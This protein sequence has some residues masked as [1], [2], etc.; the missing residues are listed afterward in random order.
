MQSC[1]CSIRAFEASV[2]GL[3]GLRTRHPR[4]HI[5]FYQQRKFCTRP[6]FRQLESTTISI[7]GDDAFI[8]FEI[9]GSKA[10]I[11]IQQSKLA[12]SNLASKGV[13][14]EEL[15]EDWH[16]EIEIASPWPLGTN[17]VSHIN[18]AASQDVHEHPVEARAEIPDYE[19][20]EVTK[21]TVDN[22]SLHGLHSLDGR[23]TG[24][25][26]ARSLMRGLHIIPQT[27]KVQSRKERKRG[28][29]EA[30]QFAKF[31]GVEMVTQSH[32]DDDGMQ[33]V[34][35]KI[36]ALDGPSVVKQQPAERLQE[37]DKKATGN[38]KKDRKGR[39]ASSSE[40]LQK[41]EAMESKYGSGETSKSQSSTSQSNQKTRSSEFEESDAAKPLTSSQPPKRKKE[42]WQVQKDALNRKFGDK[43]WQPRKR[44]SPDTLEGIRALHHSN[45]Q[46]YTTQTLAE[47][48]EV[49]PEA[50]R[51]ILK[52]KWRPNSEEVE[53]RRARWEKRGVKKWTEMAEQGVRPPAKWRAMGIKNKEAKAGEGKKEKSR[54]R[55]R[56]QD[57]YV[58]WDESETTRAGRSFAGRIL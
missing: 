9:D 24:E 30:G 14:P 39:K 19:P 25:D 57:D 38:I 50:V 21:S 37:A 43:G 8:P 45:P 51:R 52:S 4:P 46:S 33:S 6:P 17:N 22:V 26:E 12:G 7:P 23:S 3:S 42:S 29:I 47:H 40:S 10:R 35:E 5:L 15:D 32:E 16:A 28:R 36:E 11:P 44:L 20:S 53:N 27:S 54:W 55:D 58:R 48:F 41:G 34:L 13:E 18:A 2:K 1:R 56:D 49:T 31:K